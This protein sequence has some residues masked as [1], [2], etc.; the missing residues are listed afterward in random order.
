MSHRRRK[1]GLPPGTLVSHGDKKL[2]K[3]DVNVID[4]DQN[5]FKEYSILDVSNLKECIKPDTV[6]WINVD[7]IH[8]VDLIQKIGDKF[9]LHPLML[10]DIMNPNHRP[11]I[12]DFDEFIH[13]TLKMITYDINKRKIISEQ[14]S[15]VLG[16]SWVISFQEQNDDVFEPVR[17]RIRNSKGTIRKRG[18]DYLLYALVD[19]I[20]DHY[21][22]VIDEIERDIEALESIILDDK[23]KGIVHEIQRLKKDFMFLRKAVLPVRDAVGSMQKVEC[24]LIEKPTQVFLRD[25]YDHTVY[26]TES[27]E[28]DR[29]MVHSLMEVHLSSLSNRLNRVMKVLTVI[30][31]IFIPLT[32]IVGLYGMNFKFMPEIYWEYGYLYAWILLITVTVVLLVILKR[33]K[34]M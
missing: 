21:F 9:N 24:K 34:W 20:V 2:Q 5:E 28:V 8:D 3:V 14:V 31:T 19:I 26:I 27:I 6:S 16:D 33:K 4:Y 7:G 25:V 1:L 22:I 17:E 11:K 30:S 23:H 12:E 10:E 13:F 32:F 15:F 29:E 18:A